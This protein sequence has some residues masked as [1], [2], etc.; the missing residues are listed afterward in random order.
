MGVR[1][2]GD[3]ETDAA[4]GRA[5]RQ[6][7]A[8]DRAAEP[9]DARW[10]LWQGIDWD[11]LEPLPQDELVRP[12]LAK[13][14]D[15]PRTDVVVTGT[16]FGRPGGATGLLGTAGPGA[17]PEDMSR[18]TG[19]EIRAWAARHPG[20]R[21]TLTVTVTLP[22]G[23]GP[24]RP[25]S[26]VEILV[27]ELAAHAEPY[28]DFLR[29]EDSVP[30]LGVLTSAA[31]QH[32]RLHT[33]TPRYQLLGACYLERFPGQDDGPAF[34]ERALGDTAAEPSLPSNVVR[35]VPQRH[36]RPREA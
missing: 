1:F 32:R 22:V 5:R 29:A 12:L 24:V 19:D 33:G 34:C 10:H 30:G 20:R 16:R 26:V 17:R 4:W 21:F 3:F 35:L 18:W 36:R 8:V 9:S 28:A 7:Q 27:H 14:A 13:L 11:R 2:T 23:R 25:G 31:E 6:L 15:I